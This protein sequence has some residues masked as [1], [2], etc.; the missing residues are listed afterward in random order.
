MI[1]YKD[2]NPTR[3]TPVVTI[4]LIAV[5]VLV[6][7]LF[8]VQGDAGYRSAIINLG[9]IP[10]EFWNG[11]NL[12]SSSSVSPYITVFTSMFMHGGIVHLAGNMLYLWIFG[13]NVEDFLGKFRFIIL[14]MVWGL[15]ATFLH[16]FTSMGSLVPTVGASGAIAGVLGAY[17]VLFPWARVRVLFFVFYF[18]TTMTV[19]AWFILIFWFIFQVIAGLP[20]LT[21]DAVRGGGVAYWAH[22]GGFAAGYVWLRVMMMGKKRPRPPRYY[23][24]T[25]R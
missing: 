24:R 9:L 18:I 1:P 2:D 17:L 5:N 25:M 10:Y 13:N 14:Y 12:P 16:L 21:V 20:S 6:Y 8:R 23:F 19:P 22:I 4:A 11:V 15:A 7:L 3:S